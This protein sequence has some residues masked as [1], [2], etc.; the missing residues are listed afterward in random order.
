[1]DDQIDSFNLRYKRH[2]ESSASVLGD[3]GS[4]Q[5]SLFNGTN[6]YYISYGNDC[7]QWRKAIGWE[8]GRN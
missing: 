7:L 2:L 8:R 5:V 3:K 1:M 4:S 6:Q